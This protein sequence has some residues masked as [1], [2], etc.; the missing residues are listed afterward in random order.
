MSMTNQ[1]LAFGIGTGA[2]TYAY[3]AYAASSYLGPG[4]VAGTADAQATN[5]VLR[6]ATVAA[7]AVAQFAADYGTHNVNDDGSVANF[8]TALKSALD[9]LYGPSTLFTSSSPAVLTVGGAA[10]ATGT[11]SFSGWSSG[12]GGKKQWVAIQCI[13]NGSAVNTW[14]FPN[15]TLF[16][17]GVRGVKCVNLAA[18]AGQSAAAQGGVISVLSTSATAITFYGRSTNIAGTQFWAY[19]E[20]E[21]Y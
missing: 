2:N 5:T 18:L 21:G 1:Y 20:V 8:E 14:T 6:Q 9:A 15:G 13:D 7:A 4:F 11:T 16:G 17:T 19:I 10:A 3:S 12:P